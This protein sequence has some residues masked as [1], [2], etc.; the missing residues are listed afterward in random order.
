M[1]NISREIAIQQKTVANR[2]H[3]ARTAVAAASELESEIKALE[4]EILTLVTVIEE[5]GIMFQLHA[6]E[7][8]FAEAAEADSVKRV[9]KTRLTAARA[10]LKAAR[11][12]I[13]PAARRAQNASQVHTASCR[14]MATLQHRAE[15]E[16]QRQFDRTRGLDDGRMVSRDRIVASSGPED[17]NMSPMAGLAGL[18]DLLS[19]QEAHEEGRR[20]GGRGRRAR[21]GKKKNVA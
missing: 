8:S 6:E 3:E 20:R 9:T 16:S 14:H 5:S 19:E 15:L 10:E 12:A 17:S 7:G 21:R 4:A 1:S 2:E 13:R 18:R 11:R